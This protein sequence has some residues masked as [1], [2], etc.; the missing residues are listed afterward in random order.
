MPA[1]AVLGVDLIL[2][3]LCAAVWIGGL[4]ACVMQ[5]QTTAPTW[6]PA[7]VPT[8]CAGLGLLLAA[9]RLAV[10]LTGKPDLVGDRILGCLVFTIPGA[11][12]G[13][14][15]QVLARRAGAPVL[16][17]LTAAAAFTT[18]GLLAVVTFGTPA[19]WLPL[20]VLAVLAVLGTVAGTLGIRHGWRNRGAIAAGSL[21]AAVLVGALAVS[22]MDSR[23]APPSSFH[24]AGH[25]A[26]TSNSPGIT[27]GVDTLRGPAEVGPVRSY[28]L[29]ARSER[30]TLD[31]GTSVDALTFGSLP[32]PELRA[33]QGETIRVTLVNDNI[34]DGVTLHWHGYDVPNA[35]D[36]VPGVTQ[37]ALMPGQSFTYEFPAAQSGTYWYH[38]HQNASVDEPKGLYGA[39]IVDP[40]AGPP[41][42][43]LDL[44]VP[45]HTLGG[46]TLFGS[47]AAVW[48][49]QAP[50]G[51]H[52][53]LR[54]INTDQLTQRFSIAGVPFR[55]TAVDGR[56]LAP[57]EDP[58]DG[59]LTGTVLPLAAGGRY[60]LELIMPDLPVHLALDGARV[61]GL[62]LMPGAM[63]S[64]APSP[65][66]IAGPELDLAT[67]GAAPAA[68]PS[69]STEQSA[70]F[71]LDHLV[72]FVDGVPRFAFTVNGAVYPNIPA[73]VV[74][75]G[76]R[77]VITIVNRSEETHPM[78]PHGHHV[79][80]LSIDGQPVKADLHMDSI[81]V[82]PGQVWTML[83]TADN[84]GIWMDHCHNLAHARD[85]M[86]FHLAYDGISTP[87]T[88]DGASQNHTE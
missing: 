42:G 67:Y 87:Y 63:P 70:T 4:V 57:G 45:V 56:D 88:H 9:S 7:W 24:A 22:W 11:A 23:A 15:S 83:L 55:L 82:R 71:V 10:L 79:R 30:V 6:L 74:H 61:G 72:R 46:A 35:M 41:Y 49:Q 47:H 86:M 25:H 77:I 32:G 73:L 18:A 54:I 16:P 76:E 58:A 17:G 38:T 39:L 48:T 34:P 26:G 59:E 33:T 29:H 50:P 27:R 75:E 53:R 12:V 84:P 51:T 36:G 31:D 62:S 14:L 3:A 66:F 80:I 13:A 68:M 52:V 43:V 37:D 40:A 5:A 81:E 60:D 19:G 21:G 44:T 2:A 28:A 78:H 85:G 64:A 8:A 1:S 65:R 20:A 69:P